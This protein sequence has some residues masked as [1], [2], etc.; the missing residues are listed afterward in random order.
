VT[1]PVEARRSYVD[2]NGDQ[3]TPLAEHVEVGLFTAEPGRDAFHRSD[4]IV[5]ERH[6]LH[7]GKQLLKL[8]SAKRSAHAGVDPCCFYIDRNSADNVAVVR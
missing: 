5:M 2:G 8:V 3:E 6:P 1:L 7:T 4:A